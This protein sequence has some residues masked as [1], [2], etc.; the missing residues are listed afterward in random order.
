MIGTTTVDHGE[1]IRQGKMMEKYCSIFI[2]FCQINV[3]LVTLA[4]IATYTPEEW[5]RIAQ[6]TVSATQDLISSHQD[7]LKK[8]SCRK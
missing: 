5:A 4:L 3:V 8:N 7:S 2:R 1:V 6:K